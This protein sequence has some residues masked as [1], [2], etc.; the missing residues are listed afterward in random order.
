MKHSYN[1]D[2]GIKMSSNEY[3]AMECNDVLFEANKLVC[4]TP[5]TEPRVRRCDAMKMQQFYH[6]L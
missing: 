6:R 4:Y 3:D 1:D 2:S 5:K